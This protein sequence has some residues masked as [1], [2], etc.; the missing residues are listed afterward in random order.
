MLRVPRD[1]EIYRVGGA[2]GNA[3]GAFRLPAR[4]LF[5]VVSNGNG[6]DH[7]SVSRPDRCPTWD[8]MQWVRDK[9][10][11]DSDTV[12]QFSPPKD[13]HINVHPYCLHLWRPQTFEVPLPPSYMIG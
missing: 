8:E 6:W 3:N 7:V 4:R 11:D 10:F 2:P 13:K 9:F 12:L 5:V 1:M